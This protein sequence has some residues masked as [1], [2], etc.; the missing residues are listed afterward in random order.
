MLAR[1]IALTLIAVAALAAPATAVAAKPH[2]SY[3]VTLGDSWAAGEQPIGPGAADVSTHHG[4][5]DYL[6]ASLRKKHPGLKIVRLGCG[7]ATTTTMVAGGHHCT[8]EP[9]PYG[10]GSQLSYAAKWL[11]KHRKQVAYVTVII[12]GNDVASCATASDIAGCVTTGLANVKKNLSPIAK[13]IRQAA[14]RRAVIVGGSYADVVLGQW[15]KGG[16]GQQLASLSV[17]IFKGQVD[18]LLRTAYAK[19]KIGFA[20]GL[21]A[22][23]G[24]IPFSKTTTLAPYGKIP[25]AVANIC[26]YAWYCQPR[27]SGPDIHLKSAGYKKLAGVFLAEIKR[28]HG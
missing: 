21:R 28:L 14:G 3:Y 19:Q 8:D 24:L 26:R 23:G 17:S 16:N 20:D 15:V 22:F 25:Q 13:T 1:R 27:S 18:P 7:G 11:R 6:Y 12:S 9:V 4:F 2:T 10:D 5:A